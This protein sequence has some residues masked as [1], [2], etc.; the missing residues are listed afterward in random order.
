MVAFLELSLSLAFSP[1]RWVAL[2]FITGLCY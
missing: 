2:W 1:R